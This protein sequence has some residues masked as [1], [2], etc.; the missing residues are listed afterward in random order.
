MNVE[1]LKKIAASH[2]AEW[3]ELRRTFHRLPELSGHE[4]KTSERVAAYLRDTG[5]TVDTGIA[6]YGVA[7]VLEGGLPGKTALVRADMDALPV[8]EQ[9]GVEFAS[10]NPG[11][12]H[13]CGHDMHMTIGLGVARTLYEKRGELKGR[14][15]FVFQP[16]E[17]LPP[18]GAKPMIDA[19]VLKNPDVDAAF[20]LHVFPNIPTGVV[21]VREGIMLSQADDF[22]LEVVGKGGHGA[23]PH[24]AVD[25]LAAACEIVSALQV[26]CS[27]K[28]DPIQ[29]A[30]I[31]IGKMT[32]GSAHNV[33]CERVMIEG[34][35]RA[36]DPDLA[37]LFPQMI[38]DTAAGVGRMLGVQTHL[39]YIPGYPPMKNESRINA[40]VRKAVKALWG[41]QALFEIPVPILAGEDFA[42]FAQEV[43]AAMFAL[44][45]GEAGQADFYP[46]HHPKF[47]ANENALTVGVAT[48]AAAVA[49]YCADAS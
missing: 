4:E 34:T 7:A 49:D 38:E 11:A 36:A 13:A 29:P 23:L 2:Q 37:K 39:T 18:G 30:V 19:G 9:S 3:I 41:D 40:H 45:V 35:A 33:I 1:S 24:Q 31:S 12:M 26:V 48:M 5:Y 15:K 6:G 47:T 28:L 20:A 43:P 44:G 46:L 32:G 14:V 8:N 10:E 17:E 22:D 16:S 21:G 27:R 42:Y 25:A